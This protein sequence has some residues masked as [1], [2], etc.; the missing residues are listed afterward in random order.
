MWLA[1]LLL[2]APTADA[3]KG[4]KKPKTVEIP[5]DIGVGPA[6]HLITGPVYEN[7]PVHF[8]LAFS[9]EAI[10][11]KKLLKRFKSR[12]PKQFRKKI[13]SMDE[14]RISHPLIPRTF[15]IS[16]AGIMSSTGMYG[17]GFRPIGLDVKLIDS[18]TTLEVGLGARASY[19]YM[20]SLQ[21]SSP[22]HFL[23]P[24][25]E[26][27]VEMEIPFSDTTLIS[28]GWDSQFYI[29][30]EIGGPILQIGKL[31]ESIWHIGQAFVK[32]HVR[33][34]YTYKL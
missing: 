20:H 2:I 28:F 33:V 7:Q 3:A 22:T 13:L 9:L 27:K 32:F 12:I 18:D 29:P 34:P 8:G 14:L 24:G 15:F 11:N 10:L 17:I 6:A 26:A 25:L 31:D 16:P 30:Q 4:K 5:I 19:F 1:L 23:R 21:L